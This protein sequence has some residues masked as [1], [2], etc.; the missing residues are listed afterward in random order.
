MNILAGYTIDGEAIEDYN[1][2]CFLAPVL[3]S[4]TCSDNK[5]W[6]NSVRNAVVEYEDD[7]YFGDTIKMLCLIID[8][9]NWIVPENKNLSGDV[10]ADGKFDTADV[11][12]LQKWLLAAPDAEL[13]DWEA[14]DLFNDNK[15]NVLDLC[16]MKQQLIKILYK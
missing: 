16:A 3:V 7:V 12:L 10:N 15:L 6:H 11:V 2:L 8:D 9:G 13:S 4:S 14:A 1:D 5:E